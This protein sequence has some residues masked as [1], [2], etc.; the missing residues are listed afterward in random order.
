MTDVRVNGVRH[1]SPVAERFNTGLDASPHYQLSARPE[2][3]KPSWLDEFN[4]QADEAG[5]LLIN[6]ATLGIGGWALDKLGLINRVDK[7]S[8]FFKTGESVDTA[9]GL[10]S[11]GGLVKSGIKKAGRIWNGISNLAVSA[12]QTIRK[13]EHLSFRRTLKGVKDFTNETLGVAFRLDHRKTFFK[14]FPHLEGKVVV[15]HAIERN[16]LKNYPGL[17]DELEM[18]S[19]QNLRGIPKE[20]NNSL[21]LSEIQKI[22]KRFYKSHPTP[23][24]ED[25][26]QQAAQID[27]LFGHLFNPPIR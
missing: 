19:L 24:R 15:H 21:H 8:E 22:W 20:L 2:E 9:L 1:P 26:I 27:D 23:T 16:V 14:A 3:P 5:Y 17:I 10:I 12:S 4:N 13:A 18:H 7:E 25:L 11:L 6:A